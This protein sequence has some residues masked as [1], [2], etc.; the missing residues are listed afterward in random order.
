MF[1]RNI[2]L[3]TIPYIFIYMNMNYQ[4]AF[5]IL[6][7]NEQI[8]LRNKHKNEAI[9]LIPNIQWLVDILV[10]TAYKK[11]HQQAADFII[12]Q[13][14]ISQEW[15]KDSKKPNA[16]FWWNKE[17]EKYI[18]PC[19]FGKGQRCAYISFIETRY[20]ASILEDVKNWHRTHFEDGYRNTPY[21]HLLNEIIDILTNKQF[22]CRWKDAVIVDDN[23]IKLIC[24]LLLDTAE[25][26]PN[27][28]E[29][30]WILPWILKNLASSLKIVELIVI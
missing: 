6:P 23:T 24:Y 11:S 10:G 7:K 27:Y 25:E 9:N 17:K 3:A 1:N 30:P 4:D 26:I 29:E 28:D 2:L 19:V 5:F 8:T 14:N 20:I 21:I 16:Y 13:D 15:L 22:V 18:N 12:S